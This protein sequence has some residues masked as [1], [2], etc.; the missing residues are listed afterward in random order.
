MKK[1]IPLLLVIILIIVY[2]VLL[3]NYEKSD[4]NEL[5]TLIANIKE[6]IND[7]SIDE[8]F[9]TWVADNYKID[10]LKEISLYLKD[11]P[12]DEAIWHKTTGNSLIVLDDLYHNT[13]DS[14]DNIT[15][16]DTAKENT[17]SFVGD[18]S[19]AD[20]WYIMPKYDERKKGIYGILSEDTVKIMTETDI[21]V[22][23]SEFTISDRGEKM[24]NKMYTFR[25]SPKRI[26]IYNEMGADL[27]TLAN[28]HVYDFGKVAFNDML[29]SLDEYKMPYIGAGRNITEAKKP[30][31]FILNGYKIAFVNA[32]RAE[33]YILTPE[34]TETDG[35]VFR[36]Y[37]EEPLKKVISET[38]KDSDYL[39]L[40]VH[41]GKEDSH[42]LEDVQITTSKLYI[43]AGA[44]VIVGTHAHVLQGIDFYD[45]KP[46]VY[47][48]GD[49][50]FNDETKDT[51]IFQI[52]FDDDGKMSYYFIPAKEEN[53]YTK[54]LYD[55]EKQRVIDNMNSWSNNSTI[56]KDGKITEK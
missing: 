33:K 13:F 39:I 44:D 52:K 31:Y 43:D 56:D 3:K 38:K 47:N 41:W 11:N 54:I 34:A 35:G 2:S 53:E 45:H 15:I 7:E 5:P 4:E 22:I 18:V 36:C 30:Y 14:M 24:P 6:N 8:T 12:Y 42:E 25:A 55:D 49:F 23:N 21:M 27:L 48:L 16:I 28:N 29:D 17:I 10:T 46:I 37:D 20:N 26:P 40:L 32:T 9:L 51:G 50:I 19:L 1:I